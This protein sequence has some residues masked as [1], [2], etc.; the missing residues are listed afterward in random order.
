MREVYDL[1][2][3]LSFCI[4][5]R[6]PAPQ[7]RSPR[8]G[9]LSLPCAPA[10]CSMLSPP[11]SSILDRDG[12]EVRH[13]NPSENHPKV[14]LDEVHVGEPAAWF[15]AGGSPRELRTTMRLPLSIGQ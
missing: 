5:R 15:I 3:P 10:I 14:G 13:A 9:P 4:K 2:S 1:L 11:N 8:D 6:L 7:S 12:S